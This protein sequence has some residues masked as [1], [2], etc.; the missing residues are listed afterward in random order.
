MGFVA[1]ADDEGLRILLSG[2]DAVVSWRRSVQV[3]RDAIRSAWVEERGVL[4]VLVDHR[5]VGIGTHAGALRP[6]RR[7]VGTM[8]GRGHVGQQFWAVG[9][10]PDD[11]RLLVLDV[12]DGRFAQVV[13]QIADPGAV[14][15]A[16]TA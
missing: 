9:A 10:G 15:R 12:T 7:R 3:P 2:W 13:V 11:Q 8:M 1:I 14:A 16:L 4:E 6:G 5:V